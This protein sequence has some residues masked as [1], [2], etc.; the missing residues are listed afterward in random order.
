MANSFASLK[1]SRSND[2]QKLQSEVEKIN[3]P[4]NN[5]SRE[6]DRF[7]KA[8]LDKSGNGYAVIRFL[9]PPN[10]EEMAWAKI[11]NHGF[12]GPGGWYIENSLTTLG[13]KD[14]LAEYN[15]TLWNS[16]IEANKEIARKQKRRLTYISNIFVVEDK[17][18]PQNEGKVFLFRYG[19]KIFDKVSSLSNP[20]F[21][22]ETPTDVF[23]FW[24]GANFKLKIR[25]VDGFSNYDK[26][27]FITPAPLFEDDSEME[28]VW[29]EEHS[30]EEFVKESNFK[31]YDDLKARLDTVLGNIQTAAMTA[32]STIDHDD[33]P[34]EGEVGSLTKSSNTEGEVTNDENLDYFKK[35]AEA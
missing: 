5:F 9:P 15:S 4:Q 31:T 34:F 27:E 28:R 35:L 20:E 10:G 8:E 19:K 30:L 24:E 12:Q 17:T 16:G 26:S 18:N 7:W 11:F 21:E 23:N 14:P 25:K 2:L 13:Q 33:L 3:N 1:K 29:G 22:D 6:D 32:P